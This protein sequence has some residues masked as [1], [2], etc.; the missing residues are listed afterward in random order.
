VASR[1]TVDVVQMHPEIHAEIARQR[2]AALLAEARVSRAGRR[3]RGE[4]GTPSWFV[5][6]AALARR[7]PSAESR[8]ASTQKP[9][10]TTID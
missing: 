9:S 7:R 8:P 3:Q 6:L 4:K 5:R 2:Q 1:R 10:L